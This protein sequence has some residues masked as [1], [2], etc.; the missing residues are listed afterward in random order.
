MRKSFFQIIKAQP[1]SRTFSNWLPGVHDLRTMT[2]I[3]SISYIKTS[4]EKPPLN[5]ASE[6]EKTDAVNKP[7]HIIHKAIVWK[8]M[9]GDGEVESLSEI[10]EKEGLTR[11][12]VT[13]IMNLLKLPPEWKEF[14]LGLEHPREIRKYSKKRLRN[15]Q[16][17]R[18]AP[19]PIKKKLC[20]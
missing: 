2:P 8:K 20:L 15:Y 5:V 17:G 4:P 6:I 1:F 11:A 14:L 7:Q 16:A 19:H 18:Y 12:Q 13:Q 10:A 3:N 9:L